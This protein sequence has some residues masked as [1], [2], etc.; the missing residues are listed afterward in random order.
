[1]FLLC[2]HS[3]LMAAV[4]KRIILNLLIKSVKKFHLLFSLKPTLRQT[5]VV[6]FPVK[7]Q[8][9]DGRSCSVYAVQQLT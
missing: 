2:Q 3:V 9:Y 1:M 8:P 7:L 5:T 6:N 4:T